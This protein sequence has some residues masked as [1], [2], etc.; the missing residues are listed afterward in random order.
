MIKLTGVLS[1]APLFAA[2][3]EWDELCRLGG[4][5][6]RVEGFVWLSQFASAG[7]KTE[8]RGWCQSKT[9]TIGG[10]VY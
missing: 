3:V 4:E 2:G 7:P 5:M 8:V 9:P 6:P 1:S 10:S